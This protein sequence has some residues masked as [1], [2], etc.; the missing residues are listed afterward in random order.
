MS[1]TPLFLLSMSTINISTIINNLSTKHKKANEY[2][3]KSNERPMRAKRSEEFLLPLSFRRNLTILSRVTTSSQRI[4]QLLSVLGC[5]WTTRNDVTNVL[6]TADYMSSEEARP[7]VMDRLKFK[8]QIT[9]KRARNAPFSFE[10][11]INRPTFWRGG[12]VVLMLS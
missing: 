8:H 4:C 12:M 1:T 9:H 2:E 6:D 3:R 11:V 5:Q 7:T 10:K